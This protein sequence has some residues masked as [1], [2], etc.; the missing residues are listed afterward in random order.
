ME[1]EQ[2]QTLFA[3]LKMPKSTSK[4]WS[5]CVNWEIVKILHHVML[6][7]IK[8]IMFFHLFFQYVQMK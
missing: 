5:G 6:I 4:R 2:M 1:Y 7:A 8:E 3:F